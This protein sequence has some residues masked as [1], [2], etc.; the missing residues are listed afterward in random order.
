M[1]LLLDHVQE[2]T[3]ILLLALDIVDLLL[4]LFLHVAAGSLD[5][6]LHLFLDGAVL[7]LSKHLLFLLLPLTLRSLL[8]DL[9]VALAGLKDV[10]RALLGF[11]EFLPSLGLFLL[12]ES[13]TV[14]EQLV[15]LLGALTSDLRGDE[16]A[17]QRLIII[18]LVNIQVHLVSGRELRGVQLII[19]MSIIVVV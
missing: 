16:L 12:E 14:R 1:L 19:Q 6:I 5:V 7:R 17:V 8:S 3:L 9:H 2:V 11:I 10:G 18:V 13:D 15:I 4:D